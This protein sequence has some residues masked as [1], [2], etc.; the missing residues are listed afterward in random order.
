M[1]VQLSESTALF[2]DY[3][4]SAVITAF[5]LKPAR[6]ILLNTNALLQI[7]LRLLFRSALVVKPTVTMGFSAPS[8][9]LMVCAPLRFAPVLKLVQPFHQ[10]QILKMESERP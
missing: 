8:P 6:F 3:V 2:L 7:L 1:G 5:V 4:V 10:S 9:A